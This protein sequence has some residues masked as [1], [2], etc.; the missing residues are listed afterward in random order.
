[1]GEN[2]SAPHYIFLRSRSVIMRRPSRSAHPN[3]QIRGEKSGVKLSIWSAIIAI[4]SD[5]VGKGRV[6]EVQ[7]V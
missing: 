2:S 4:F 3:R 5:R 7:E 1:M 6:Q